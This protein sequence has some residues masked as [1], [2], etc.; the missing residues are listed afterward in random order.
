MAILGQRIKEASDLKHTL[1]MAMCKK[2]LKNILFLRETLSSGEERW[3][4][5]LGFAALCQ[6]VEYRTPVLSPR[7]TNTAPALL[8]TPLFTYF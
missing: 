1:D 7:G 4:T 2:I 8:A 6:G 5:F 3:R